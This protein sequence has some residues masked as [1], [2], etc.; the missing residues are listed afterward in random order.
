MHSGASKG[1][2]GT[3]LVFELRPTEGEAGIGMVLMLTGVPMYWWFKKKNV[4][5]I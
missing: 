3:N 2:P 5:K 4:Q 1:P